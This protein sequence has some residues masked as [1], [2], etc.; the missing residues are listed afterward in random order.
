MLGQNIRTHLQ[1]SDSEAEPEDLGSEDEVALGLDEKP[2]T[3][4]KTSVARPSFFGEADAMQLLRYL[5]QPP[6]C[7][8]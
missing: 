5:S 3:S 6:R 8:R 1:S 4:P 2:R 7:T